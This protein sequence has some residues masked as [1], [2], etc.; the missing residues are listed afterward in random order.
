[1]TDGTYLKA[2]FKVFE[3]RLNELEE[4][5]EKGVHLKA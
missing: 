5:V 1:M 3:A 4:L 2:A